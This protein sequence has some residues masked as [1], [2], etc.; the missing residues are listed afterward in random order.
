MGKVPVPSHQIFWSLLRRAKIVA[1]RVSAGLVGDERE[2][3]V[4]LR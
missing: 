1:T 2:V 4:L 3:S